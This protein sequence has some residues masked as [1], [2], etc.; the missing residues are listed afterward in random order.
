MHASPTPPPTVQRENSRALRPFSIAV[1]AVLLI[2]APYAHA[3]HKS[4]PAAPNEKEKA[5]AQEK[6]AFEKDTD[7][8]YKAMLSKIPD[9]KQ[10][11]AD[12][13]GSMRTAP[14]K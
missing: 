1:A 8:A 11:K 2:Q 12:P 6:R 5:K 4:A 9:A 10:Q 7:E 14:Q 3:Q 13:W